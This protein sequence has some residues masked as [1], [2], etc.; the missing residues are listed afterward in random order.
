MLLH[1]PQAIF[2]DVVK[3]IEDVKTCVAL[4]CSNKD[5]FER[6]STN[7]FWRNMCHYH[8]TFSSNP[9]NIPWIDVYWWLYRNINGCAYCNRAITP[10]K[11]DKRI[12][13][14]DVVV[15]NGINLF[16]CKRCKGMLGD[17]TTHI[18]ELEP[19][20]IGIIKRLRGTRCSALFK[21]YFGENQ[22]EKCNAYN[23]KCTNC[24][25]NIRNV[26]C[27]HNQ[28]G[29]CCGCKYHKSHYDQAN[30]GDT[31][32]SF[33]IYTLMKTVITYNSVKQRKKNCI[34]IHKYNACNYAV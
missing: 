29:S 5:F 14:S 21:N 8:F 17:T 15:V 18:S 34:I 3:R 33:D 6:N 31:I 11:D 1:L 24:L 25:K 9:Y 7:E 19:W 30:V 10:P 27:L 28:C 20:K 23:L 2:W 26:R 16:V 32:V 4:W 22:I 13:G 12:K